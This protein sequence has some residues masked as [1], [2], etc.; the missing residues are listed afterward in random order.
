[1]RRVGMR[2]LL[3]LGLT[4]C[5]QTAHERVRD[6]NWDGVQLYQR[7]NISAATES[8]Q[9]A[10]QLDPENSTLHYNL[11]ECYARLGQTAKAE[12]LYRQCLD[13]APNHADCRHALTVH[14]VRQ[15]R[16]AEA[17]SMVQ[18][19]L[20]REPKLAAAYAEDGWLWSQ[21]GDLPRAQA[22][23]QQAL[24]L[25]PHDPRALNEL[26]QLYETMNRPD[27]AAV[28][29]ERIL[30]RNPQNFAAA[31]RLDELR[32]RGTGRPIPD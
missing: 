1:M 4:G 9:A 2:L 24:D 21:S 32:A 20:A 8:F 16:W 19:W 27:R 7:G 15:G 17:S 10:L 31:R 13:R 6:Y 3:V 28:L 26:A 18:N 5:T 29:Y 23:L 14:L 11:G 25:D 30:E 12:Q 22:R